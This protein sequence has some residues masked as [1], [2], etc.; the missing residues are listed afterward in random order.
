MNNSSLD[1]S[2]YSNADL[3][4]CLKNINRNEYPNNYENLKAEI[5]SRKFDHKSEINQIRLLTTDTEESTSSTTVSWIR[6]EQSEFESEISKTRNNILRPLVIAAII[7]LVIEIA[8]W[9]GWRGKDHPMEPPI[10]IT[11]FANHLTNNLKYIPIY[12]IP[13]FLLQYFQII[14]NPCAKVAFCNNC[15]N[16]E[17]AN[18]IGSKCKCGGDYEDFVYWKPLVS[19]N[20]I[21]NSNKNE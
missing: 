21:D 17:K 20:S 8:Y 18:L 2:G 7:Y 9:L 11:E 5:K 10:S 6:K 12:T 13:I 1:Y 4:E 19:Y 15:H 16:S 14:F 3:I